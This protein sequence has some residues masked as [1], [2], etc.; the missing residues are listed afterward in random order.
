MSQ[1]SASPSRYLD[2]RVMT[3]SQAEL[4]LMLLDGALRF[5]RQAQQLWPADEERASCDR[6][7]ERTIDAVEELVRSATLG[8]TEQS[9]RLEEE[10]AFAFR[11]I[12]LA[13]LN[14]DAAA[15]EA[16]LKLLA[17]QRETWKLAGDKIKTEM[18]TTT[19]TPSVPL[20]D[21]RGASQSLSLQG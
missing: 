8:K 15:L 5:G 17:Y 11:Q 13:Q 18:A 14:H 6:L 20:H 10:Y 3:A 12:T 4:Q 1:P 2:A 7:L 19:R 16:A 9:K 21:T